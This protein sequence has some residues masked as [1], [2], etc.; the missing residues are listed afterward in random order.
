MPIEA[1]ISKY[2]KN[3]FYIYIAVCLIAAAW[4]VYDGYLNQKFIDKHTKEDGN[5]NITLFVNQKAPPFL[6]GA[7]IVIGIYFY[8][9][10]DR[11]L[12]ADES[13][14]VINDKKRIPYDSIQKI[15]KTYFE[16][17][18]YFIITYKNRDNGEDSFKLSSNTYD[19]LSEVLDHLVAQI[20]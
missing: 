2:K 3:T 19:N 6:A 8:K 13:D 20:T 9:T 17:K 14:L 10:K 4:L 15:D 18:G 11:K 7:A 1:P 5:P 16:K 12:I